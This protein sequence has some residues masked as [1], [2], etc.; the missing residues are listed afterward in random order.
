MLSICEQFSLEYCVKFNPDKSSLLVFGDAGT[1]SIEFKL[2]GSVIPREPIEKHLGN[3]FGPGLIDEHITHAIND[4]YV[5]TNNVLAVFG[6]CHSVVKYKLFKSFCMS[7]YGSQLWDWS[8]RSVDRFCTAW[9]KCIRRVFK[10]PRTTHCVLL[11]L[12]CDD[13]NV[14]SQLHSRFLNFFHSCVSSNNQCVQLCAKQALY[15]SRS[16]VCNSLNYICHKYD[17]YKYDIVT[18]GRGA[19]T[20]KFVHR[21]VRMGASNDNLAKA[22][23]IKDLIKMRDCADSDLSPIEIKWIL[24]HLCT[25]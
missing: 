22:G 21:N 15:G 2:N 20:S 16:A 4:L 18:M 5:R 25:D 23:A 13:I 17:I 3:V 19:Y 1:T 8:S 24:E 9:R 12:V 7:A 10:L 6:K 14:N 11:P